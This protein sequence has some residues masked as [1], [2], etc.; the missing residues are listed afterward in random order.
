MS[1]SPTPEPVR[2]LDDPTA[3]SA[4]R[5]D[6][7]HG[8]GAT[9]AGV[10]Y[11]ATLTALRTAIGAQTGALAPAAVAGKSLGFKLVVGG[12]V[13]GVAAGLWALRPTDRADEGLAA[14]RPVAART[15]PAEP[16]VERPIAPTP[17]AP[18]ERP[19]DAPTVVAPAGESASAPVVAA[20]VDDVEPVQ[21]TAPEKH[22]R[23][24]VI[25]PEQGK[26]DEGETDDYMREAKL[27]AQARKQLGTDAKQA[28]ASTREHQREFPRG[29]LVEERRAIEVR[30]LAQLGRMDEARRAAESF[31]REFGDGAH[32]AA[33]RR[34]IAGDDDVP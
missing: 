4:L 18:I 22:R 13:I 9:A 15:A 23:P 27:V 1:E 20:P 3:S 30:A 6:L 11:A 28:L 31:L 5:A 16:V 14:A 32:A 29:A 2:W 8:A 12:L 34:A 10:D 17:T 33:V 25:A 26:A 24:R 7:A 19:R 21:D